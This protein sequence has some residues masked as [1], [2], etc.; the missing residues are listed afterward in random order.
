MQY[1][2][3]GDEMINKTNME[4]Y[5]SPRDSVFVTYIFL[6]QSNLHLLNY[7]DLPCTKLATDYSEFWWKT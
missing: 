6:Y 3:L 4:I 7:L 1:L 2:L 5:K